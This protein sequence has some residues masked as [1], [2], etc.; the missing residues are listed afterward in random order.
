MS[1][2]VGLLAERF[3]EG[4]FG[5]F[6]AVDGLDFFLGDFGSLRVW[7]DCD[8]LIV[9]IHPQPEIAYSDGAQS[10]KLDKYLSMMDKIQQLKALM[11][12]IRQ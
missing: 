10:L 6:A 9:E 1:G 4:T 11:D 12:R 5:L 3:A 8:G 7:G 2:F